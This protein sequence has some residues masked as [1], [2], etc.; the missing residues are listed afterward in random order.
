MATRTTEAGALRLET[1]A[2]SPARGNA[3][4]SR[5]VSRSTARSYPSC[6]FIGRINWCWRAC[7]RRFDSFRSCGVVARAQTRL[8]VSTA[9]T[10]EVPDVAKLCGLA[11]LGSTPAG[12][13]SRRAA[14]VALPRLSASAGYAEP[15][16]PEQGE[17]FALAR[18]AMRSNSV[19]SLSTAG[20]LE[21]AARASA[22]GQTPLVA[23]PELAEGRELSR[24]ALPVQRRAAL[25][26]C[27]PKA[28]TAGG[29]RT[30]L[31][32]T[33]L[34][35][36]STFQALIG[37]YRS[38]GAAAAREV[39]IIVVEQQRSDTVAA[40][41]SSVLGLQRGWLF[42]VG[43]GV[44]PVVP[45]SG[46]APLKPRSCRPPGPRSRR[47]S[48]R[49]EGAIIITVTHF[50]T[51]STVSRA[52]VPADQRSLR[53]PTEVFATDDEAHVAAEVA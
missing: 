53:F 48:S 29:E 1:T 22:P 16:R 45:P 6:W 33:T 49:R 43:A 32:P 31:E 40:G 42:P 15:A 11:L 25:P 28:S 13:V 10:K 8:P 26:I 52:T 35:S 23:V 44:V 12:G 46:A 3:I 14:A 20:A 36:E 24:P 30:S 41:S 38:H 17:I 34:G 18:T 39:S 7:R 9:T 47:S 51:Y 21:T 2:S 19:A 50:P 5:D 37:N 4:S 27:G